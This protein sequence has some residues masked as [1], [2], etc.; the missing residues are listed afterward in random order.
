MFSSSAT[1]YG[2]PEKTPSVEDSQLSALNPFGTT[3]EVDMIAS[4]ARDKHAPVTRH[5]D[6]L[7]R[8]GDYDAELRWR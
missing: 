2:Q 5:S 3:K 6:S 8:F 7:R 1:V 4:I